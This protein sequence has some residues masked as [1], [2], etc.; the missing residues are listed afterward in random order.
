[1]PGKQE[2]TVTPRITDEPPAPVPSFEI[3]RLYAEL[4]PSLP[5]FLMAEWKSQR[6]RP[7][8]YAMVGMLIGGMIALSLI[9]D[10]I[11]LV[12]NGHGG[13]AIT[14][15]GAGALSMVAGFRAARL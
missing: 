15:I 2:N 8:V 14:L 5:R 4:D 6:R 9:I 10:F 11:Y 3:L 13:Y 1:M 7:F 12:M